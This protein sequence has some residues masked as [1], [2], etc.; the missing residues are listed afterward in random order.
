MTDDEL[1]RLL[2]K[3]LSSYS[4]AE[5]AAGIERRVMARVSAT[6]RR[7]EFPRWL[8]AAPALAAMLLAF[9]FWNRQD[10]APKLRPIAALQM[11]PPMPAWDRPPAVT[12][13]QAV[14]GRVRRRVA[15][16]PKRQQFPS[17]APLTGEEQALIDLAARGPEA[18]ELF[19][20]KPGGA[21]E[22]GEIQIRPLVNE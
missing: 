2:E 13:R 9:M 8:I 20:R 18:L 21:I 17:P 22:I 3:G 14:P 12:P 4:S 11:T 6:R 19:A 15:A 5:P 1:D 10:E 16:A 7:F